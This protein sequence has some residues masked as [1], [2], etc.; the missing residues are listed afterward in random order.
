MGETNALSSGS[1][2]AGV[3]G[4]KSSFNEHQVEHSHEKRGDG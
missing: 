4:T 3:T 1:F 2:A